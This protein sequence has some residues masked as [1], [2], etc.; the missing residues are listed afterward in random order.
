LRVPLRPQL[1]VASAI[2]LV[3]QSD[4][5]TDIV[6]QA[7]RMAKPILSAAIEVRNP[8]Q[9]KDERVLAFAGIADPEKFYN[10]LESTGAEIVE[11]SNFPDHHP[12][13]QAECMDLL[14]KAKSQNITLVTTEKDSVR[15]LRMGAAQQELRA[16][17]KVLNVDLKF[18]NPKMIELILRDTIK[19]AAEFRLGKNRS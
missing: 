17:A 2:L 1:A 4:G 7:A 5:V 15:L 18:E 19:R 13:T 6:R 9:W 3:G 8:E 11:R 16:A 10:S 12:Y 14:A